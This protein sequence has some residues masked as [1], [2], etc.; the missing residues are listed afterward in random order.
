MQIKAMVFKNL[1]MYMH[2]GNSTVK[3]LNLFWPYSYQTYIL[4]QDEETK[5]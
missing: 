2:V 1:S 5:N 4:R 3:L